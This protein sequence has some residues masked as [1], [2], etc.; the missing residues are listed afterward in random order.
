MIEP[1][2]TGAYEGVDTTRHSGGKTLGVGNVGF[3]DGHAEGRKDATINPP[4]DPQGGSAT[5][6]K[7]SQYWDPKQTAGQL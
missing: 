3:S 7:N 2:S 4:Q 6:L 1:S 5:S